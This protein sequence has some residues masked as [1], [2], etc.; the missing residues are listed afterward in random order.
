M[1]KKATW[2]FLTNHAHVMACLLDNPNMLMRRIADRVG[3]TERAVQRI[4]NELTEAGYVTI[5]KEGRQNTYVPNIA[6]PLRHPIESHKS[7]G[8]LFSFLVP[9]L[10]VTPIAPK[11]DAER[12]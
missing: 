12:G 11:P 5:I 7:V 4:I 1:P 2:T 9:N 3:I 6:L 10:P 8:E